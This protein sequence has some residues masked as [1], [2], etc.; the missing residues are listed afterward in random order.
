MLIGDWTLESGGSAARSMASVLE[1]IVSYEI[2]RASR[3]HSTAEFSIRRNI[4]SLRV[5][6]LRVTGVISGKI[7]VEAIPEERTLST[8]T[9][10]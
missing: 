4:A 8:E 9:S 6:L 3:T 10:G 1:R 5:G 7:T 2:G